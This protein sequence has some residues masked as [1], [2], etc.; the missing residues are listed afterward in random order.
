MA[1]DYIF[2]S[3]SHV[4]EDWL[5]RL[6]IFLK[7]FPWGQ[8][9]KDGGALWADPYIRTGE[10]WRREI[11]E[12]LARTRIGV[13]LVSPDF[14]ASDFI[15]SSEL[16]PLLDGARSDDVTLVC[17]PVRTSIVDLSHP[18][19]LDYQWPRPPAEPLDLLGPAER[20][21]GLAQI[22]RKLHDV[23]KSAGLITTAPV[24]RAPAAP[25]VTERLP[26][27]APPEA[28]DAVGRLV[29]VPS[30]RPHHI[31]RL[32]VRDRI[33]EA[34]LSGST[35]TVGLSGTRGT[36]RVGVFGQGGLGKTVSAIDI[37][38]DEAV[39]RAFPGGIFWVTLG[40]TPDMTSLQATLIQQISGSPAVVKSVT[41][42]TSQLDELMANRFSLI[43]LDDVWRLE[44]ARA[45]DVSGERCRL[46]V[47]TRDA[48]VLSALG[49]EDIELDVL[50]EA[51]A[52]ELLATWTGT[53][54]ERLPQEAK[55]LVKR[56]GYLPLAISVAGAMVRDGTPWSDIL[57]ALEAGNVRFL[58][59]PYASVF[60]SLR[61]SI[62]ALPDQDRA[63][64]FELAVIPEDVSMPVA[65]VTRFWAH[66]G[67]RK[68]YE[69]GQLL[70]SFERRGL[71]YVEGDG[72]RIRFHDL[73]RDFLQLAVDDA[74]QLHARFLDAMARALDA[75]R[76][77]SHRPWWTLP[78]DEL[79]LWVHLAYHL[80]KAGLRD[81]LRALLLDYD[82]IVAKLHAA[83]INALLA[84]YDPLDG[85]ATS[86][87]VQGA[88]RL[89]AH[90]LSKDPDQ[91]APQL[92]GRMLRVERSE[93]ERLLAAARRGRKGTW[94]RPTAGSLAAPGGSLVR[95][96]AGHTGTVTAVA[97]TPDGRRAVSGSHDTTLK[98]WD[99]ATGAVLQ[100]LAGHANSVTAVA[101][102]P[103]GR[104]AVS[105]SSTTLKVWDLA[106]KDVPQTLAGHANSVT[107]V[108]LTPD[109]HR[110]VSASTDKTLKV[111]DLATGAVLQTLE[112]HAGEV[113][114]VAVT[115]DG[116]RAI[117][118]SDDTTLKVWDLATGT[119]L[120]TLGHWYAVTAVALT[121]DGR[122]AVS[123]SA[124]NLKVWDLTTGTAVQT[125]KWRWSQ[126]GLPTKFV[127]VTPDGRRAVSASA[128][129]LNV[130]D[131][132]T[133]AVLL[134]LEGH[135]GW[136]NP[137][138]LTPDGRRAVFASSTTLKVWDL[139]TGAVLQTLEG[140]AGEVTAVAVTP[141]GR[142]AVSASWDKTLRVW[143]LATGTA[144]QTLKG[145]TN[146][147]NA[148]ALTPDGR[149]AVS[150]SADN[151]LKVWD[152]VTGVVIAT[153]TAEG[154]TTCCAIAPDGTTIVAGD[155]VRSVHILSLENA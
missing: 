20:D 152:L 122:R 48:G 123:A 131:L 44:H 19:L 60:T 43:V 47:T 134:R 88:L 151:T 144:L 10:R 145:H 30:Q 105:A 58:D 72:A 81:E 56:C 92:L 59:H 91:V 150:T 143:D 117:S 23:A 57:A 76:S 82:W 5:N 75:G 125:L 106:T 155:A 11:G 6:R 9:Y 107:A 90:V 87:L 96:L 32:D 33:R 94:L 68:D 85:D 114:A 45:F 146:H 21:A 103:D 137:V 16:P 31:P 100:T 116:R 28:G 42:G 124:W 52:L 84:D 153:F 73:Q 34:L 69:C 38:L 61:L 132:A 66:S 104:C 135:T 39:R 89:S 53:P 136:V 2:V 46:L 154:A 12:G 138:A 101:L 18:E 86:N 141:D 22:V 51:H 24:T 35:G 41:E 1:R 111:W 129:N 17:V 119:A 99:L 77:E 115:P 29:G 74:E 49:A 3:Y 118:A 80:V 142:R 63:R 54:A 15:A 62:D 147:V 130:W 36:S 26:R 112:G 8:S 4:D 79:Y 133:G 83:D 93:I 110:A 109:D 71:L 55:P 67:G 7:P 149:R 70:T 27:L 25:R 148:V 128:W 14:L 139:A 95:T 78:A 65:V 97:V 140:H 40:Q 120:Q 113:K 98:V 13:L 37:A 50:D 126:A 64:Y 108:A 121:P 102:T 127:A